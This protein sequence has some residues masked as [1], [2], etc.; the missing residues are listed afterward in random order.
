MKAGKSVPPTEAATKERSAWLR[1]GAL[2]FLAALVL[3]GLWMAWIIRHNNPGGNVGK[4]APDFTAVTAERKEVKLSEQLGKPLLL[5]FWMEC[6]G[7]SKEELAWLAA[8][9]PALQARGI[10][11]IAVN[12]DPS[13]E[14][15]TEAAKTLHLP[16]LSLF[17]TNRT[18]AY[19]YNPVVAPATFFIDREG[20][21]TEFLAGFHDLLKQ[22]ITQWKP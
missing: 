14:R 22:D 10:S 12:L 18:S 20:K 7:P 1:P 9:Y 3:M 2:F 19:S 5:V 17:D 21:V 11:V 6:S 4:P 13:F 15:A 8:Q 16:Y